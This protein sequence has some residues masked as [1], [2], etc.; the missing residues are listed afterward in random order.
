ME[1]GLLG[2]VALVTGGSRG[3]GLACALELARD[4]A[5]VCVV[6]RDQELLTTAVTRLTS[7]GVRAAAVVADLST[8]AGCAAAVAACEA[9]LGPADILINCAGAARQLPVLDLPVSMIEEAL[10]LKLFGYLRLSQLVAPGMRARGWGRIVNIAGGAGTSPTAGN[11]PTSLANIGVLNMTHALSDAL[12]GDG[13]LVNVICPGVTDT[14][15]ARD[16]QA[17]AAAARGI[18]VEQAI[19]EAGARLPAGRI[20]HPEEIARVATFL[21]SEACSYVFASAVYMDGGARRATP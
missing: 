7:L 9:T 10:D 13:V 15:R 14:D 2:K 19:A 20:A 21:A 4:G 18:E 3:I 12:A 17:A 1:L 16:L 8:E 6:A 11:L 5:D